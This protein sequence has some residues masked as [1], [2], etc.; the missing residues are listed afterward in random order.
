MINFIGEMI[1]CELENMSTLLEY[2][3]KIYTQY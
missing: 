1:S 3:S 2:Q